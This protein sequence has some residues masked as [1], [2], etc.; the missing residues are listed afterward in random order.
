MSLEGILCSSQIV[1]IGRNIGAD[2][3]KI[4]RDFPQCKLPEKQR[5]KYLSTIELGTL[6]AKKN[7]VPNA[8]ASLASIVAA[9]LQQ[10][11]SKEYRST[12]W[13]TERLTDDQIQYAALLVWDVL[14][15]IEHNSMPLSAATA[16]GQL[17]SLFVKNHEV[18]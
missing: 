12:E 7:V 11:L 8:Q 18:A 10:Y 1:K 9:T 2:F 14:K 17:V 15:K 16:V 3:A 5:N 4:S 13:A 6:A